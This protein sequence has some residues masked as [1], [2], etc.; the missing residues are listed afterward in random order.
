[1]GLPEEPNTS[2]KEDNPACIEWGD[3][4]VG[5]HE[6]AKQIDIC[7]HFAHEVIQNQEMRPIKIHTTLQHS[8]ILPS[9]SCSRSSR[10]AS[11]EYW[12]SS[13]ISDNI[14]ETRSHGCHR[15]HLATPERVLFDAECISF[16]WS[17]VGPSEGCSLA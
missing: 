3:H 11:G 5:G 15:K 13:W 17:H 12:G 4:V 8:D 14:M 10:N 7:R 6:H 9:I 16:C 1:M 2:V